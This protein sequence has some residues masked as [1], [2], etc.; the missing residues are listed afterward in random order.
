R[1][2]RNDKDL[3]RL[4]EEQVLAWADA[5]HLL[6]GAW[7]TGHSGPI[8][9]APGES[10]AAISTA[11]KAGLRGLP[12]GSSL[13]RLLA[14]RRGVRNQKDLPRLTEEQVLA[15]ADAHHQRT[16]RWPTSYSGPMTGVAGEGWHALDKALRN[17]YRGLPG[18]SSLA[19]LLRRH[20]G[21]P[22]R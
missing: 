9:E 5:H 10:W 2:V 14:R 12:G 18:G 20:R 17:G 13:A 6:L 16:G 4:T 15:W 22:D 19:R 1:G 7:P 8:P 21:V 3:P 11:L